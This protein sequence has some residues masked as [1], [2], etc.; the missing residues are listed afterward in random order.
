MPSLR[1]ESSSTAAGCGS[2]PTLDCKL[3]GPQIL[4]M[5]SSNVVNDWWRSTASQMHLP[6]LSDRTSGCLE[7]VMLDKLSTSPKPLAAAELGSVKGNVVGGGLGDGLD[8]GV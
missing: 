8:N 1:W 3:L 6:N 7:E 2:V 5:K 4:Q